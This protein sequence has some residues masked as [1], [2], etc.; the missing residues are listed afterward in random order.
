MA[1]DLHDIVDVN[2]SKVHK[3]GSGTAGG[4]GMDEFILLYH[5][6]LGCSSSCGLNLYKLSKAS[7]LCDEKDFNGIPHL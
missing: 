7:F 6:L 1:G 4:V 5:L 2:A 3:G